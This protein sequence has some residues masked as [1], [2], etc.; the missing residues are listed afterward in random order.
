MI[1]NLCNRTNLDF[2]KFQRLKVWRK[3]DFWSR[4]QLHKCLSLKITQNPWNT[5]RQGQK[6]GQMGWKGI[7]SVDISWFFY[8]SDFTWNQFWGFSK[9]KICCFNTF[10]GFKLW[11]SWIFALLKGWY[12]PNGQNSQHLK[13]QK[14]Q[15]LHFENPQNWFHVKSE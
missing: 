14:Q 1:L 11:F 5:N 15:F 7:H 12:L 3:Y 8:H 4:F 2:C 10:R 6:G 13:W 9:C